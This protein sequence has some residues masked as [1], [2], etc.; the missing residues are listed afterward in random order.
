MT[1]MMNVVALV[2]GGKDSCFNMM[3]AVADG[4]R[5]VALANLQPKGTD[6]L[7]SYMYQTVGHQAISYYAEAMRLPVYR[8]FISGTPLS[9]TKDYEA[10]PDDEVEDLYDLLV[11]IQSHTPFEAVAVG[12]IMSE[13]QTLRVLNI[14]K[15]LNIKA[16][17][18]LWQRNQQ[19]LLHEMVATD[20]DAILIK[21]AALGLTPEKHLGKSVKDLA[22]YLIQ[23]EAQYGCNPCG[24]GGEYESLVL[25]CPLFSKRVVIDESEAV[26]VSTD[27]VCPIGFLNPKVLHL[28]EKPGFDVSKS[29]RELLEPYMAV[30]RG[31]LSKSLRE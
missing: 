10:T 22:E 17:T 15:R 24:E 11:E 9:Q 28:E 20:V 26:A 18:Y 23:L 1:P 21:V 25:D 12:A 16:L 3:C 6:E 4:H 8:R 30:L 14:C 7:D 13:Y 27:S 5:I 29:Q 19:E 2:S 31:S